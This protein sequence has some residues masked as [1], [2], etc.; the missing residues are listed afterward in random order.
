MQ[1]HE[2]PSAAKGKYGDT[3]SHLRRMTMKENTGTTSNTLNDR[4]V[5]VGFEAGQ[6]HPN[7]KWTDLKPTEQKE[8]L[9]TAYPGYDDLGKS[10]VGSFADSGPSN[11]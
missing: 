1:P 6:A 3:T 2:N 5:I 8:I 9:R 7:L 10:G 11:R 4:A